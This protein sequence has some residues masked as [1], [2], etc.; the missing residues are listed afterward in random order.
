MK[1]RVTGTRFNVN[2]YANEVTPLKISCLYKNNLEITE[3][4]FQ[5]GANPNE[6]TKSGISLLLAASLKGNYNICKILIEKGA[7]VN[8][9]DSLHPSKFSFSNLMYV[10]KDDRFKIAK[11][12]IENG[13]D[14]N[15]S[16]SKFS[17]LIC[18]IQNNSYK[19]F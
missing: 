14:V 16:N 18:A 4:L 17:V 10:A 3:L 15:Y 9:I 19:Q 13:A 1:I 8:F 7:N 12:L 2:C 5:Y 6:T 11:L